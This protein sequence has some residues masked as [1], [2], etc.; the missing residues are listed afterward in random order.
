MI[1]LQTKLKSWKSSIRSK[2]TNMSISIWRVRKNMEPMFTVCRHHLYE[3]DERCFIQAAKVK[4][5]II[6]VYKVSWLTPKARQGWAAA[7]VSWFD[8]ISSLHYFCSSSFQKL[9]QTW[10]GEMMVC[11]HVQCS[12]D[13]L[14]RWILHSLLAVR[15]NLENFKERGQ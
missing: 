13:D 4:N 12:S 11:A 14:D 3:S 5:K 7:L 10:R 9:A 2:E 15:R 6:N 8:S 1:P